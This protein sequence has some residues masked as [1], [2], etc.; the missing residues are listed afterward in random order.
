LSVG[1]TIFKDKPK[2]ECKRKE[3]RYTKQEFGK[4]KRGF[5]LEETG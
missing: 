1:K 5:S 3:K 4:T 2:K